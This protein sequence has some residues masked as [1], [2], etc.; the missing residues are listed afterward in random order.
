MDLTKSVV[1]ADR[2]AQG[3]IFDQYVNYV[4]TPENLQREAGWLLGPQRIDFS[5][6]LREWVRAS[7]AQRRPDQSPFFPVW[8]SATVDEIL[9][10]LH[11]RIVVGSPER[12]RRK[13]RVSCRRRSS[14]PRR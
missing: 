9:S 1:T 5:G 2:F 3:M 12:G 10:A 7:G 8:A 6:R 14:R 4:G 13:P 11:E